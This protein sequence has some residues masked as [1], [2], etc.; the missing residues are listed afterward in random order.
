MPFSFIFFVNV[1]RCRATH[2]V[3]TYALYRIHKDTGFFL[4]TNTS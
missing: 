2:L 3:E 1:L 4:R